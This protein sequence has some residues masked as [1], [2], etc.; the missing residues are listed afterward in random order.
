MATAGVSILAAPAGAQN[1][2]VAATA[3]DG[4]PLGVPAHLQNSTSG[5]FATQPWDARQQINGGRYA[6]ERVTYTSHGTDI[7]GNVFVPAS[8]G[9]KPAVIVMGP[10]ASVKEQSPMQYA[11]RLVREG[12]VA[13]VFAPRHHGESGGDPRRLESRRTKV[14]D[15]RA[16]IDYLVQRPDVDVRQI[17]IL[18]VCQGVNWAIE[19]STLDPRVKALGLVAGHYLMPEVAALDL[20]SEA[21]VTE[22][23]ARGLG[24]RQA[25]GHFGF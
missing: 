8:S 5:P 4:S 24:T 18:G 21:K 23:L 16:S 2:S 1:T 9:R 10:V 3:Q 19:A 12:F 17:H 22:R 6:I 13:L 14:E 25:L 7:V 11:S 20:G 15:L